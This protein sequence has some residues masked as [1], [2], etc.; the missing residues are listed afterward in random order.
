L[1]RRPFKNYFEDYTGENNTQHVTEY[2]LH[3]I[4]QDNR[5]KRSIYPHLVEMTEEIDMQLISTTLGDII[6]GNSVE[7]QEDLF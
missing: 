6:S 7:E 3:L 2:I 5:P 4:A 1:E